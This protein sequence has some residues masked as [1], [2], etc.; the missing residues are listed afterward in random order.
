MFLRL[1]LLLFLLYAN[2]CISQ[3]ITLT[4]KN[5]TPLRFFR[6]IEK[7]A[8]YTLF[9]TRENLLKACNLDL[10]YRN[11]P[12][13][14]VLDDY[15]AKQPGLRYEIIDN[16]IVVTIKQPLAISDTT[17]VTPTGT[18]KGRIISDNGEAL[19]GATVVIKS[20]AIITK[21][22]EGGFFELRGVKEDELAEISYVSHHPQTVKLQL[23]GTNLVRLNRNAQDIL[24]EPYIKNGFQN[25]PRNM[26]TGSVTQISN[27]QFNRSPLPTVI[28]RIGSLMP[29]VVV[30]PQYKKGDAVISIRGLSTI[31]ASRQPLII[32][33]NLPYDGDIN[34]INPNDI[35]KIDILKDAAAAAVWGARASH[36][37][38]VITTRTAKRN[39]PLNILV[40][41]STF[42]R[43][44]PDLYYNPNFNKASDLLYVESF[45]TNKGYFDPLLYDY[46]TRPAVPPGVWIFDQRRRGLIS[47]TDS[48]RDIN[49]LINNDVRNDLDKYVYRAAIR[50]QYSVNVTGG[51]SRSAFGLSTSFDKEQTNLRYNADQRAVI[52]TN[53]SFNPVPG[54]QLLVKSMFIQRKLK[55]GNGG[56]Q[57]ITSQPRQLYSYARLADEHGNYLPVVHKYA[58]SV[59]DSVQTPLHLLYIPLDEIGKGD[60][61][62]TL[63]D[64]RLE[65]SGKFSINKQWRVDVIA[66]YENQSS[67]NK[68]IMSID[69]FYTRNLIM[70]FANPT[71]ATENERNPIPY[72]GIVTNTFND[73]VSRWTRVQ[74][75][76]DNVFKEN[77]FV[78]GIIGVESGRT[79][80]NG[81]SYRQYGHD[82]RTGSTRSD[83]DYR[84]VYTSYYG[85]MNPSMIPSPASTTGTEDI[86]RSIY[87]SL[88]YN[89]DDKITVTASARKDWSNLLGVNFNRRAVVLWSAGLAFDL[90][91]FVYL[92]PIPYM[93]LRGS[94]GV[95]GNINK[96]VTGLPTLHPS[97][98]SN[99]QLLYWSTV[100]NAPNPDLGW[101]QTGILNLGVDFKLFS[102]LS[103]VVEYYVKRGTDLI[104]VLPL[105]PT[106]GLPGLLLPFLSNYTGL[107]TKG[108]DVQL[109][110]H[111]LKKKIQWTTGVAFGYN[112]DKVTLYDT[113]LTDAPSII[114]SSDRNTDFITPIAGKP[115][116]GIYS[117]RWAGLDER[118][119]DPMGYVDNKMSKDY[120][121]IFNT[122]Y[123]SLVFHGSARPVFFGSFSNTISHKRV[124]LYI[125]ISYRLGYYFRAS[126]I[127]YQA[128]YA[129]GAM[130]RDF[131]QRWQKP[132]DESYT[133]IPSMPEPGMAS[134]R[135]E[136]YAYSEKNVHRADHIRLE[137]IKL[138]YELQK[139]K[140]GKVGINS[141][142]FFV[143]GTNLGI[144][145]RAN[146]I[147]RDP[148]YPETFPVSRILAVGV[149]A[150]L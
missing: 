150:N 134:A 121:A 11:A 74:V 129:T 103:G 61:Q 42:V 93:R 8:Q 138:S 84:T 118:N 78:T 86:N 126:T 25:L 38:I 113:A 128:L 24:L 99:D 127:N 111:I 83:L 55:A 136:F 108:V 101:E 87:S 22:D 59:H 149:K 27:E 120:E 146:R 36:G 122:K 52:N 19:Q 92:K 143:Q 63:E 85:L 104:G 56:W 72:G 41:V 58:S 130:H 23:Q 123:N 35:E 70:S 29:G 53:A 48:A 77:H 16:I 137:D 100:R 124:S 66:M 39:M 43:E 31:F 65:L 133:S 69:R 5:V 9:C 79:T 40:N 45:L 26:S 6:V 88:A 17:V 60:N 142:G 30:G 32:L 64:K 54:L 110:A 147:G 91:R 119:G 68:D 44:K 37:V 145:W 67:V 15:F 47:A 34:N 132:G 62:T 109:Q 148:D 49:N 7:Q 1:S 57:S 33:D 10:Y 114:H 135:D 94:Y 71:G 131:E 139:F 96:S 90:T 76:Y 115:L 95:T 50:Q 2:D 28:D 75:N 98:V 112:R 89:Y 12:L 82:A 20:S 106:S 51:N 141:L 14:D 140:W 102:F 46:I 97:T 81:N 107:K 105:P 18:V 73:L 3:T 116:F 117:Y 13:K 144:L 4:E 80:M 21:T 125:N